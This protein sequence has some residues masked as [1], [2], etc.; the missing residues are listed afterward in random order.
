MLSYSTSAS[1]WEV[2]YN[3]YCRS[4]AMLVL[5]KMISFATAET[6]IQVTLSSTSLKMSPSEQNHSVKPEF[7]SGYFYVLTLE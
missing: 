6:C 3:H 1:L 5:L 2:S 7:S 4:A